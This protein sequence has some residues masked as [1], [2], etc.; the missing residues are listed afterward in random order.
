M[1]L[2]R[3]FCGTDQC[4]TDHG[5]R[6]R[7]V[8]TIPLSDLKDGLGEA[9]LD[10]GERLSVAAVRRLACDAELIPAVLGTHGE[11]LDVGRAQR[12]VTAA[13]WTALFLRDGHCTFPGCHRLPHA[14][15][16]HHIISWLV[17]GPTSLE[18]LTPS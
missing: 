14:C 13:L 1:E 3:R 9:V 8:I 16:A 11:I 7:I 10:T 5:Q 2:S 17:G 6:P 15:D 4:P 12:L 18:N